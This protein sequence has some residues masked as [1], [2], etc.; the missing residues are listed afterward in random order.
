VNFYSVG[1]V[2]IDRRI[3]SWCRFY[4]PEE[5]QILDYF[6]AHNCL[7]YF[8]E[9]MCIGLPTFW[10]IFSQ[11]HLVTLVQVHLPTR[12]TLSAA[13]GTLPT[14]RSPNTR[15]SGPLRQTLNRNRSYETFSAEFFGKKLKSVSFNF[16]H[17]YVLAFDGSLVIPNMY[18]QERGTN[19]PV[20]CF[21]FVQNSTIKNF[22]RKL[23]GRN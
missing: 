3:G 21:N 14:S 11:I 16:V 22:T 2:T 8:W 10:A 13:P 7:H 6:S 5:S 19:L 18:I 23:F 1:I 15:A 17:K 20:F 12:T 4:E 9:K